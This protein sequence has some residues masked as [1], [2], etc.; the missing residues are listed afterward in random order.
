MS[1]LDYRAHFS[2]P[3]PNVTAIA[4]THHSRRI[5]INLEATYVNLH[6]IAIIHIFKIKLANL[7]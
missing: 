1:L 4:F 6:R 3:Q 2:L 5:Y 7:N